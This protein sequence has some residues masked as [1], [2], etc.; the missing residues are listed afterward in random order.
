MTL[1]FLPLLAALELL[2]RES[3]SHPLCMAASDSNTGTT[4][5]SPQEPLLVVPS[6]AQSS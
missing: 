5:A 2:I 3:S 4:A 6:G 1:L